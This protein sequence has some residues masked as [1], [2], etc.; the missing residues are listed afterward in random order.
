MSNP[1]V[2][3]ARSLAWHQVLRQVGIE[4]TNA[5]LPASVTCPLCTQAGLEVYADEVLG[6]QWFHCSGCRFAGDAIELASKVWETPIEATIA[7]LAAA[8]ADVAESLETV[9]AYLRD[10][11]DY[12]R[13]LNVFWSDAQQTLVKC[14]APTQA[15]R[16][17]HFGDL[18][19]RL[20][21]DRDLGAIQPANASRPSLRPSMVECAGGIWIPAS[22]N[23]LLLRRQAPQLDVGEVAKVL[24]AGGVLGAGP[25]PFDEPGWL[26]RREWIDACWSR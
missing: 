9:Q 18:I 13:R 2:S 16:L 21:Q 20:R 25:V 5:A 7:T 17:D 22:I 1:T 14:V 3:L 19:C 4:V 24:S 6:G 12:R 23:G 8:G 10:H 11:V 15:A 26:V